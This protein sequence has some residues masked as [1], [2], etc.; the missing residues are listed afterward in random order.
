MLTR[1]TF[2][3]AKDPAREQGGDLATSR[4]VMRLAADAFNV[5]AICLAAEG[6]THRYDLGPGIDMVKVPKP[7]VAPPRLM[8][9]SARSRRSLVHERFDVDGLLPAIEASDADVFVAEHSYMAET[10]L[11]STRRGDAR[12]IINTINTESQVWKATRGWLGRLECPR[13]LRDEVRVA[14]AAHAVG[15]YD[16]EEAEFYRDNGVPAARWIDLTIPPQQ[17]IDIAATAPRLVFFGVRDW[18]PN[19][20]AFLKSLELW[21]RIS[22]GIPGAELMIAGAKKPGSRDPQYPPGV[23]DVGFVPDLGEF[24]STCRA[25][26][27]P[28]KTGGGV[29]AKLLDAA[30][31]GL[32]V[33]A[34]TPAIGSHGELLNLAA[35][36]ADDDFVDQ[37]RRF[38]LDRSV[39]AAAGRE[40]YEINRLHWEHGRPRQ[41]IENLLG[42]AAQ[43]I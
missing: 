40:L 8:F 22:A 10:F 13:I 29:R 36:D 9:K 38:L 32:P 39:A 28:I 43:V 14:R 27:A 30:S 21:P 2:L 35:R 16:A 20:E 15:T 17:Q 6:G 12:L 19:Q 33:V 41:S 23:H 5:S 1:V 7:P 34:T 42:A 3:L 25:L 37:C 18:P 24:L 31:R 26:M 11:R 4:V